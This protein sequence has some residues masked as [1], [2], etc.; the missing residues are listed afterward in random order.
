MNLKYFTIHRVTSSL[1]ILLFIFQVIPVDHRLMFSYPIVYGPI[2]ILSVDSKHSN[3]ILKPVTVIIHD[4]WFLSFFEH[5]QLRVLYKKDNGSDG[6]WIDV[7]D[8]VPVTFTNDMELVMQ[9][10][11]FSM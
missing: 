5:K 1:V 10:N 2:I 9:V 3:K 11:H 4:P 8:T 6:E 7:T